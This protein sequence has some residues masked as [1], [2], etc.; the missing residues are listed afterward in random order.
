MFT[1]KHA[2]ELAGIS[3]DTLRA[4]E[5]R[6]AVV[7]PSRTA[8]GYRL[9][10]AEQV[11][12]LTDMRELVE[13]GWS[14]RQAAA[15]VSSRR[16]EPA[17]PPG[18]GLTSPAEEAP[19]LAVRGS[20]RT[21]LGDALVEA[22]S[23]MDAERLAEVL[24]EGFGRNSF[25]VVVD[26]WLMPAVVQLGDAWER[27]QISEASEHL[28]S[29]AI[30][31]RIAAVFEA[32]ARTAEGPR[33]VIGL[34]AGCHHELGVF[35]FACA[36]RRV[37]LNVL[38]VGTNLPIPSWVAA[39]RGHEADAAVLAVPDVD[40]AGSAAQSIA[41]L[42]AELPDLVALVGGSEQARVPAARPLGHVIGPAARNLAELL[43]AAGTTRKEHPDAHS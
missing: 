27:G 34:P 23:R 29:H 21:G 8:A 43:R 17:S 35:A 13:A 10:D 4:W 26:S 30:L 42:H 14:A 11:Q 20:D 38:Y 7:A 40:S 41:S 2:A 31:R 22:A 32:S 19:S 12:M 28:A 37:G 5:R 39:V 9:Y 18:S 1:V 25:E 16:P 6:Y 15:E 24:D 33:V 3:T 36:A